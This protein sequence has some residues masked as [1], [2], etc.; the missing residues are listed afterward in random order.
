MDTY[1]NDEYFIRLALDEARRAEQIEQEEDVDYEEA[2]QR[3]REELFRGG[4]KFEV[5][6]NIENPAIV[7]ETTLFDNE[8]YLEEYNEEDYEDYD[9]YIADVEQAV[10]DDIV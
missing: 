9:D 1:N 3:A 7:G 8:S 2:E 4:H 6:L 10:A 5:Y